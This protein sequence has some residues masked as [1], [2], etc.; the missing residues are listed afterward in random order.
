M[1]TEYVLAKGS[2]KNALKIF[3]AVR[4]SIKFESYPNGECGWSDEEAGLFEVCG[5]KVIRKQTGN[6]HLAGFILFVAEQLPQKQE[7]ID[8]VERW[9]GPRWAQCWL[10]TDFHKK[11]KGFL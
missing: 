1:A 2:D 6:P 5:F 11:M 9:H 4:A 8:I 10:K 3:E 7:L